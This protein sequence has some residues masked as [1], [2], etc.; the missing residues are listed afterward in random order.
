MDINAFIHQSAGNW[1][2][3]RTFYQAHHPEPDNGKANLAF[4]LLPLDHPEV[5]RFAAAIAQAPNEH[6]RVF[7]SSWDT[8]VD[9]G[10]PK[11]IGSSLFAFVINPDQPTQGQAFSL[12]ERTFAQGRY[13]LGEDQ[14]LIVTLEAGEVK[15]IERQWFGNEN[16]RLRTNIVTGKTGVL[17]TAFYSEIRRIIEPEKTAEVTAEASN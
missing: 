17:Q 14:I 10:K 2:A 12:D 3:Q 11:A 6:W 9:W 15:I 13:R 7:Q 1:F 5:S 16:L 4:E 8:S